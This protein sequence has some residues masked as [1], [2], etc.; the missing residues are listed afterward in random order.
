MLSPQKPAP[1]LLLLLGITFIQ[2]LVVT[3]YTPVFK[4]FLPG[5]PWKNKESKPGQAKEREAKRERSILW[6]RK[7]PQ[8][9]AADEDPEI[10]PSLAR[11]SNPYKDIAIYGLD[12][13]I[14]GLVMYF[15]A[16]YEPRWFSGCNRL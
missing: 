1:L 11:S 3:F 10:V 6:E 2:S 12:V 7:R 16:V 5:L 14:C 9:I 13:I 4:I 8:P 15:S